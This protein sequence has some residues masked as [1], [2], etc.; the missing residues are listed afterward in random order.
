MAIRAKASKLNLKEE[1]K[2]YYETL[3]AQKS[4]CQIGKV[5]VW[6]HEKR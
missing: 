6:L 5:H 3:D 1:I 4:L 2:R